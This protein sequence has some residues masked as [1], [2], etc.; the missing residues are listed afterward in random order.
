MS[1][2]IRKKIIGKIRK[3]LALAEGRGA[4]PAEAA[5]AA[6]AAQRLIAENDV[7][8]W[9]I[10]SIDEEPIEQIRASRHSPR[11]WRWRLAEVVAPAFRCKCFEESDKDYDAWC[12]GRHKRLHS[13]HWMVFYGYRTDAT[14]AALT[15]DYLYRI[16]DR[17]ATAYGREHYGA[18]NDFAKGFVSGV[19][20]ELERQSQALMIVVPPKVKDAYEAMTAEFDSVDTCLTIR[21]DRSAYEDG[22]REGKDAIRSHRMEEAKQDCLLEGAAA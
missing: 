20:A 17:L 11:R 7:E 10:H 6:L 4:T 13:R 1:E 15:F 16:G 21:G 8:Q 18:Y 3:L 12:S 22:F 9:E 19:A 14:A 5:A 2:D